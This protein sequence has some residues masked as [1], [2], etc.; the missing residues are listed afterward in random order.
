MGVWGEDEV[1][2]DG[3]KSVRVKRINAI[4]SKRINPPQTL[5][6]PHLD[7]LRSTKQ[8][9]YRRDRQVNSL[10]LLLMDAT[11]SAQK[12]G[13]Y[14]GRSFSKILDARQL[15]LGTST[16]MSLQKASL[17]RNQRN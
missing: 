12:L 11:Y 8:C 10:P 17:R 13:F 4:V 16:L 9:L 15:R 5:R 6:S 7:N 14:W 2:S 3:L 1:G